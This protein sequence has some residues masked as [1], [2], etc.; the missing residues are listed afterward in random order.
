MREPQ[1]VRL[2]PA[3]RKAL[4]ERFAWLAAG[5]LAALEDP[6]GVTN[7]ALALSEPAGRA[8]DFGGPEVRTVKDLA[9]S[10]LSTAGKRRAIVPIWLPGKVF[11]AYRRGGNLT[12]EHAAGTIT[13][14]QYLT[15]QFAAGRLPYSDAIRDY[16]RRTPKEMR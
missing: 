9:H 14:E 8:P 7:L 13:F 12:S 10:Y 1:T 3:R 2:A 16:L 6:M 4:M 11:H 15:E 5:R